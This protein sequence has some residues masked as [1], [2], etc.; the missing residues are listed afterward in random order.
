[1]K[2]H[3]N[4]RPP[5]RL[6]DSSPLIF[7]VDYVFTTGSKRSDTIGLTMP[8]NWT[9]EAHLIYLLK[10]ALVAYLRNKYSP[11]LFTTSDITLF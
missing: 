9:N 5:T 2:I 6:T 11:E 3:A 7:P 10:V 4:H 8:N 1:M